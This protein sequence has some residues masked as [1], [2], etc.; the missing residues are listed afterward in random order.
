MYPGIKQARN[1]QKAQELMLQSLGGPR[2]STRITSCSLD[3]AAS[4]SIDAHLAHNTPSVESSSLMLTPRE[5]ALGLVCGG[6]CSIHK[7][8]EP[9]VSS[10]IVAVSI[11]IEKIENLRR[12][13]RQYR[14]VGRKCELMY[15]SVEKVLRTFTKKIRQAL[16]GKA[17]CNLTCMMRL[18][19]G[20]ELQRRKRRLD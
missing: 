6:S 13:L 9:F 7:L 2:L 20:K 8:L 4:K 3:N 16:V 12:L 1:L 5:L 17:S 11:K 19:Q 15:T 14:S 10:P 18:C